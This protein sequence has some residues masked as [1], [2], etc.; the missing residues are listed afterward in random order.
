MTGVPREL[1]RARR[2]V[3]AEDIVFAFR[4]RA[5]A[6]ESVANEAAGRASGLRQPE[7]QEVKVL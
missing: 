5:R 7:V 4:C 2:R 1:T 3:S 6:S